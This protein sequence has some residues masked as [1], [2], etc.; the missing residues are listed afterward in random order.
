[1]KEKGEIKYLTR[2]NHES[3]FFLI[4]MNI[5]N[6]LNRVRLIFCCTTFF[7]NFKSEFHL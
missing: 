5:L 3:D 7:V 2:F 6:G 4:V 1:M